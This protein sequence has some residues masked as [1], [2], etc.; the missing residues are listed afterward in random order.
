MT[1]VLTL[2]LISLD[3]ARIDLY[4]NVNKWNKSVGFIDSK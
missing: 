3:L 4:T 2:Q 1:T